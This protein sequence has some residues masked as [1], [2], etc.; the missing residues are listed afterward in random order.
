MQNHSL[1]NEL[2]RLIEMGFDQHEAALA[3]SLNENNCQASTEWLLSK[4][5]R[6][7]SRSVYP[8]GNQNQYLPPPF[9]TS[10]LG[11]TSPHC[12][13]SSVNDLV[14]K[15]DTIQTE[16]VRLQALRIQVARKRLPEDRI[17]FE[18]QDGSSGI[19]A[20]YGIKSRSVYPKGNQNQYLPPPFLT[21]GERH[22]T[23]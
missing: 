8:K 12:D 19:N 11:K 13:T 10:D 14:M 21:S 2:K 5:D 9:L 6:I 23:R 7:K 1:T 18:N 20:E 4:S 22:E 3:L 15:L 16:I 17:N